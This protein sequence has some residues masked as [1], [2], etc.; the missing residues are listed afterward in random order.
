MRIDRSRRDSE[1]EKTVEPMETYVGRL[2]SFFDSLFAPTTSSATN[3]A[4]HEGERED[5]RLRRILVVTHGGP[6]KTL[7]ARWGPPMTL[8]VSED[9]Q[10][11]RSAEHQRATA[12]CS[13]TTVEVEI[14]R[15]VGENQMTITA[16]G[17]TSHLRRGDITGVGAGDSDLQ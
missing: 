13:I 10:A 17:D 6:I 4:V 7:V 14:G 15:R 16:Y 1:K 12:N 11:K 2:L 9:T 3:G 8:K 5:E